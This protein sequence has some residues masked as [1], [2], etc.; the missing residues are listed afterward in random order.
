MSADYS[1]D[2][3]PNVHEAVNAA[4]ASG[5]LGYNAALCAIALK[6]KPFLAIGAT[7]AKLPLYAA[8]GYVELPTLTAP[9]VLATWLASGISPKGA[10]DPGS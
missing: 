10:S 7:I 5:L 6:D 4:V 8:F 2:L 9:F 1:F 3:R